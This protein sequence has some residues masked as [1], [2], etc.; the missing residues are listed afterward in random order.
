MNKILNKLIDLNNKRITKK[1]D[2][3]NFL[4]SLCID[5]RTLDLDKYLRLMKM[6]KRKYKKW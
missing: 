4:E 3:H 2:N 6:V 1:V 5:N